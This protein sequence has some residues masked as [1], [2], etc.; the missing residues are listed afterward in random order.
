MNT[1][2][3]DD[4]VNIDP[5]HYIHS[6]INSK[7]FRKR[8]S[9]VPANKR[10]KYH[11]SITNNANEDV[12]LIQ[13]YPEDKS[14]LGAMGNAIRGIFNSKYLHRYD[15]PG[16]DINKQ[17]IVVP[18]KESEFTKGAPDIDAILAHEYGHKIDPTDR[19]VQYNEKSKAPQNYLEIHNRKK[20]DTK[21]DKSWSETYA[22]KT[23]TMYDLFKAGI[24]DSRSEE[25]FTEEQY[26][27]YIK[28]LKKNNKHNRFIEQFDKEDVI[29]LINTVAQNNTNNYNRF[30]LENENWY[31]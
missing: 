21:H 25:D 20:A 6:Y 30:S 18:K 14:T 12:T 15:T 3:N 4:N 23:M 5:I 17:T 10:F 8:L 2:Y 16:Y 27:E 9:N 29:K 24:Y 11:K 22:D 19:K 31:T 26:D 28:Y 1:V 7:G 13:T